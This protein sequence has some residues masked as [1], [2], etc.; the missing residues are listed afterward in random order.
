MIGRREQMIRK[1]WDA[2][3]RK[4]DQTDDECFLRCFLSFFDQQSDSLDYYF[5]LAV[6]LFVQYGHHS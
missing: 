5:D 2:G 3:Y 6:I 4:Y 1:G